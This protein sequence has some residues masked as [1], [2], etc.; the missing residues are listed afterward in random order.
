MPKKEIFAFDEIKLLICLNFNGIYSAERGI[1]S[2][3]CHADCIASS[4]TSRNKSAAEYVR[5]NLIKNLLIL[6]F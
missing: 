1:D 6:N 3:L 5:A 4:G 2:R